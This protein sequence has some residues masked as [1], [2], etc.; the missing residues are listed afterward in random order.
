MAKGITLDQTLHGYADGHQLLASSIDLTSDQQALLLVMTDLSGPAF[1][2]GFDSYLTGYPLQD[3]GQYCIARTWFAPEMPRPGCVWTHTF[4]IHSEDLPRI[5]KLERL[6]RYFRRPTSLDYMVPYGHRLLFQEEASEVGE[7]LGED[8]R[9]LLAALYGTDRKIVVP[10]DSS[11]VHEAISLAIYD[12]QWPRLRRTFRFCTGA[13]SW[14]DS[15]FDL[16]ICPPEET[17]SIAGS[18]LVVDERRDLS[19]SFEDWVEVAARDLSSGVVSEYRRFLWQFGSDYVNG[20]AAFRPLTEVFELLN[21]PAKGEPIGE[22]VLSAIAHFFPQPEG[23]RRLKSELFGRQ[24]RFLS[25]L[26]GELAITR[27]L[28]THPA[29][30]AVGAD[31]AAIGA[32]STDLADKDIESA[33]NLALLAAQL[34]GENAQRYLDAYFDR[35]LNSEDVLRRAPASLLFDILERQPALLGRPVLWARLDHIGL[36]S[37]A[38]ARF[39]ADPVLLI[40]AVSAMMVAQAWDALA[41]VVEQ[42]G[43]AALKRI[44][45]IIDST[46]GDYLDYPDPLYSIIWSRPPVVVGMLEHDEIGDVSLKMLTAEI[47]PRAWHLRRVGLATWQRVVKTKIQFRD[48]RR[49]RNSEIFLLSVGLSASAKGAVSLVASS[50]AAVYDAAAARMLDNVLWDRLE[51]SLSWYSP[52]W[53]KCARL[54]RT[55]ARAF[56]DRDWP[57]SYFAKT[58]ATD[59]QFSRALADLN[60]MWRGDRYIRRLRDEARDGGFEWSASRL[61]AFERFV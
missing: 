17:H 28:V 13:L 47:D 22:K 21:V 41:G 16:S 42:F 19:R 18:G 11:R 7:P 26:G 43:A 35:A 33:T 27:I 44:F 39:S 55:V 23:G 36:V 40:D 59:E 53:D 58:F 60:E 8:A 31:V 14:R 52:N 3:S 57:A 24:G 56:K 25:Q 50:F 2:S 15:E 1:R 20:R 4:L 38:I 48:E 30:T 49:S 12:Q 51:P 29:A 45:E 61:A 37:R 6:T 9:P 46:H 32:R 5:Q 54:V 34:G 10:S